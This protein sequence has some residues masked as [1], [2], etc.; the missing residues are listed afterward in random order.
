MKK[1]ERELTSIKHKAFG[2]LKVK[3]KNDKRQYENSLKKKL[4][5]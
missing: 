1:I 2:K 4:R 3:K 5:W